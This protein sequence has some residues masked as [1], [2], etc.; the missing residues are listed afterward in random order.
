M[1]ADRI[2]VNKVSK[3]GYLSYWKKARE[4]E[5]MMQESILK[6][7]RKLINEKSTVEYTGKLLSPA[8]SKEL[9]KHAQRFISWAGSLLPRK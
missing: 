5:A 6:N 2:R 8:R 9:C 1:K 3:N 7:I 4:L